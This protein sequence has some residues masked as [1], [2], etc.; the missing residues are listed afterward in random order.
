MGLSVIQIILILMIF[1]LFGSTLWFVPKWQVR[2][3][4][5]LAADERLKMENETRKILAE[6]LGGAFVLFGLV[7]TWETVRSTAENLRISQDGLRISQESLRTSQEGQITERFTRAIEQLGKVDEGKE[8]N[9]AIRLGGIRGLEKLAD[10]SEED[11]WPIMEVLMTYVREHALWREQKLEEEPELKADVKAILNV[12][13]RRSK[14]YKNGEDLGLDL[15]GTDLRTATLNGFNFNGADF[16]LS[17][18]EKTR[19]KGIR[20]KEALLLGTNLSNANLEQAELEGADLTGAILTGANLSGA[21]LTNAQLEGA[22]FKGAHLNKAILNGV[23]LKGVRNLTRQQ[24]EFAITDST[25][26]LPDNL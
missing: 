18:L 26:Q 5:K 20:L 4:T 21:V 3:L 10:D 24:L 17:H 6:I 14:S 23:N 11:Y 12:F 19:L 8:S 9:L 15:S 7:F 16:S 2:R 22:D 13:G 25:T 1:V